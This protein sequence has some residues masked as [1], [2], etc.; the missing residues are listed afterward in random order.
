MFK[1]KFPFFLEIYILKKLIKSKSLKNIPSEQKQKK[2]LEEETSWST[3][4]LTDFQKSKYSQ[5]CLFVCFKR[6]EGRRSTPHQTGLSQPKPLSGVPKSSRAGWI[7][8]GAAFWFN[9]RGVGEETSSPGFYLLYFIT[10]GCTLI[11]GGTDQ[12]ETYNGETGP[13]TAARNV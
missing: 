10:C 7:D 2:E 9:I 12:E 3:K 1:T 4:L 11:S 5:S 8:H 6:E 13:F